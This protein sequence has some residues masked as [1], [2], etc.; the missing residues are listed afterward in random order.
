MAS[1]QIELMILRSTAL[2]DGRGVDEPLNDPG[3]LGTGLIVKG[4]HLLHFR[5][6][7]TSE[8]YAKRRGNFFVSRGYPMITKTTSKIVFDD[9]NV[10]DNIRVTSLEWITSDYN[11]E[12]KSAAAKHGQIRIRLEH[13]CGP[14]SLSAK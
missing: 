4:S 5:P 10:P 2:D 13:M 1:G 8:Y 12:S 3:Q 11:E 14:G 6:I 7:E 9:V